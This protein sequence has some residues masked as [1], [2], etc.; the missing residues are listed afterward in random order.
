MHEY[1]LVL[2]LIHRVEQIA[3]ERAAKA[4]MRVEVRVG[5]LSGVEP[6]L[7]VAAYEIARDGTLCNGA[8]LQVTKVAARWECPK[9]SMAVDARESIQCGTCGA[10][11]RLVEGNEIL[12]DRMELDV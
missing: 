9:C 11:A 3:R 10:V 6:D 5:E 8:T 4:V 12:F 1:S 7:L 2:S